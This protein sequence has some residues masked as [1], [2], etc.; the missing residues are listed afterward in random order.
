MLF[1][2]NEFI[3]EL[4]GWFRRTK[5]DLP[6]RRTYDPYHVWLSEI[7]LQQTQMDRGVSYFLRWIERFPDVDAVAAADER[8]ILKY[9][10]GLGYYARARNLHRAARKLVAEFAGIVPCEYEELLQLPGIGPYTAAAIASVAGNVD[11]AVVDANVLRVFAR[12]FDLA[13]SVKQAPVRDKI[14]ALAAE[15]LP[16]GQARTYNQALMDLGGL[17]CTP[18]NPRC[19]QCPVAGWCQARQNAT[20]H[21]RPETGKAKKTVALVKVAV[22]IENQGRYF[23]QQRDQAAVWGGLWEFPGGDWPDPAIPPQKGRAIVA[24]AL[25]EDCGLQVEGIRYRTSVDHQY[26]HHRITLHCFTAALVGSSHPCLRTAI[27]G[28][29]VAWEQLREFGYPAGPRKFLEALEGGN[30]C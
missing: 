15:L 16:S 29:W 30:E 27:A 11:I 2:Q 19:A 10:E 20:V 6:W 5:R 9:W 14:G 25:Q 4:L 13:G 22:L 23:I 17:I 28:R 18:K 1:K 3:D 8:E 21:L 26:T 12:L 7:M 24:A